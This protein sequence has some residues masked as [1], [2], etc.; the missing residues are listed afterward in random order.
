MYVISSYRNPVKRTVS[1]IYHDIVVKQKNFSDISDMSNINICIRN[2]LGFNSYYNDILKN[3]LNININNSCYYD[4]D[5]GIGTYKYKKNIVF[6]FTCLEHFDKFEKN[7]YKYIPNLKDFSISHENQNNLVEYKTEKKIILD[8]E[9]INE[10][11]QK[12]KDIL[13]YYKLL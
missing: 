12:E 11:Y 8:N 1:K 2:D 10:L 13:D 4:I 3:E 6:L 5:H 9:I 7:I